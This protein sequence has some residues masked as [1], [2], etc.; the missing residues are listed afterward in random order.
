M[1]KDI[2]QF[3]LI[4]G[5]EIICEVVEHFYED[6]IDPEG[7]GY[8]MWVKAVMELKLKVYDV[9]P[10]SEPYRYYTLNPW[11]VYG[12][13]CENVI[14]L[15]SGYIMAESIPSPMLMD[16]YVVGIKQMNDG[17][18]QK[19]EAREK[20]KDDLLKAQEKLKNV[21]RSLNIKKKKIES[22]SDKKDDNVVR[23][24]NKNEKDT[25]H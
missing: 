12:E 2:R 24:F 5:E 9:D 14:S 10:T 3:K 16:Q 19:M 13:S 1:I 20:F 4:N 7:V 8:D 21:E 25:V 17:Y 11:M 18:N 15:R 23:L 6:E 22:E